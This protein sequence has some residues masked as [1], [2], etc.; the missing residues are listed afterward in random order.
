MTD[1]LVAIHERMPLNQPE[2]QHSRL[3]GQFRVQIGP[4]EGLTRL[5]DA[6]FQGGQAAKALTSAGLVQDPGMEV[7]D[8]PQGQV[9]HYRRR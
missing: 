6:G 3:L 8:L 2:A 4:A 9:T 7:Q 1:P 5:G